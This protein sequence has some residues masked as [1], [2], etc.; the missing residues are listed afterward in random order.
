MAHT[1]TKYGHGQPMVIIDM[2]STNFDYIELIAAADL[3]NYTKFNL[4]LKSSSL[5]ST[6]YYIS[7]DDMKKTIKCSKEKYE[8]SRLDIK[9]FNIDIRCDS[10]KYSAIS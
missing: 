9:T 8:E 5:R 4:R 1:L 7:S 6:Q 10:Y 2:P 3:I